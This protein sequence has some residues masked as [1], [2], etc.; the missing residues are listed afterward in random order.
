MASFNANGHGKSH[1][2][3][4]KLAMPVSPCHTPAY[5]PSAVSY[6]PQIY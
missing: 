1:P 6:R 3:I 4:M 2:L 5:T